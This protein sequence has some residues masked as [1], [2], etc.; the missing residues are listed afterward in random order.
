MRDTLFSHFNDMARVAADHGD[1]NFIAVIN[2]AKQLFATVPTYL[3]PGAT[4]ITH[5]NLD[6]VQVPA[7]SAQNFTSDTSATLQARKQ[8]T[9]DMERYGALAA[10][11]HE[12]SEDELSED[13]VAERDRLHDKL[14]I[15]DEHHEDAVDHRLDANAGYEQFDRTD[16]ERVA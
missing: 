5:A 3:H 16:A 8:E 15:D 10:P 12:L 7:A 4:T 13:E 9:I 1:E 6:G 11:D 2:K 14:Q